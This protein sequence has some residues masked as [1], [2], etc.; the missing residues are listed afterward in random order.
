M[1]SEEQTKPVLETNGGHQNGDTNASPSLKRRRT[2]EIAHDS[3]IRADVQ[4]HITVPQAI[5]RE[6]TPDPQ[7]PHNRAKD[8][9]LYN[10]KD[11]AY[12]WIRLPK[13]RT[14]DLFRVARQKPEKRNQAALPLTATR[15]DDGKDVIMWAKMDTGADAN[16]INRSTLHELLGSSFESALQPNTMSQPKDFESMGNMHFETT[17]HVKLNFR[18]GV[19]QREFSH[20][21]FDVVHDDWADPNGDGI[22]NVLL[23][24]KFVTDHSMMMMDVEYYHDADPDL[25]VIA[26]KAEDEN[27]RQ[28]RILITK[29]PQRPGIQRPGGP[30]KR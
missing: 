17:H 28:A 27:P 10:D 12:E 6:I 16:L 23:G 25:E 20:V 22:P 5:P 18:A 13:E 3:P 11:D 30:V 26:Q 2:E 1:T 4:H 24:V 7:E 15:H 19:S 21:R 8:I 29:F 9:H 14:Y